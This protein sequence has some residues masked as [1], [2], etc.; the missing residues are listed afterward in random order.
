MHKSIDN[1]ERAWYN[2]YIPREKGNDNMKATV[3]VNFEIN[4]VM[5][6][7]TYKRMVAE[8]VDDIMKPEEFNKYLKHYRG[9]SHNEIFYMT[10]EDKSKVLSD[11]EAHCREIAKT[12]LGFVKREV[13][14]EV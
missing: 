6:E 2:K 4:E 11:F 9:F 10:P 5:S 3:Y 8:W 14:I 13:E 12:K 7:K 1:P